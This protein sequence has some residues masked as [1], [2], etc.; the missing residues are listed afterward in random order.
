[1]RQPGRPSIRWEDYIKIKNKE[2]GCS[3]G[4]WIHPAQYRVWWTV[5]VNTVMNLLLPKTV[6]NSLNMCVT[7]SFSKTIIG[8][9]H[10]VN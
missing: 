8:L 9:L 4:D 5:F 7:I 2:L 10:G 3:I 1:M 6:R